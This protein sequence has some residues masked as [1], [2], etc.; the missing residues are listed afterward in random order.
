MMP[1]DAPIDVLPEPCMLIGS[2]SP[3]SASG[4]VYQHIYAATGRPTASVPL[5]GVAEVDEAI[6]AARAAFASWRRMP[7]FERRALLMRL[8]R[9]IRESSAVLST[10]QTIESGVP[11]RYAD[12]MPELAAQH[13]EYGAGWIDKIAGAVLPTG[14][15]PALDYTQRH[16][17]G[18]VGMIITW[19]AALP[20]LGQLLGATLTTGNTVVIKASELAPFTA[21]KLAQLTR[22]CGFPPGVVNV[23]AG[24]ALSGAAL[25]RHA[26]IDKLHFTGSARTAQAVLTE[27]AEN[28]TPTCLELGGKSALIIFDDADIGTVTQQ[29]LSGAI[30]LSGQG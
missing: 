5:A 6:S 16:P 25:A 3:D 22:E 17:Y 4:G 8:A 12:A 19:N 10:I 23:L 20:A 2:R 26:G 29:A 30:M 28:V 21:F 24:N 14:P 11:R 7:M 9:A 18:V 27:A 13:I 15:T 1:T